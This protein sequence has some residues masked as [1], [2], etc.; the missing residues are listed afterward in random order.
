[1][2]NAQ[3]DRQARFIRNVIK[4][5][6]KV[7]KFGSGIKNDKNWPY[8]KMRRVFIKLT[9][10]NKFHIFQCLSRF[11]VISVSNQSLLER[12]YL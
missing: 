2:F 10:D 8:V 3:Y 6:F 5:R 4:I 12:G 7:R 1:M 9:Y 11:T